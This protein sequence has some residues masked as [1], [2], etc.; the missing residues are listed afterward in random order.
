MA[1]EKLASG[2][3]HPV[4]ESPAPPP[5]PSTSVNKGRKNHLLLKPEYKT[6]VK[7]FIVSN[8]YAA[9]QRHTFSY[10]KAAHLLLFDMAR[11]S[12]HRRSCCDLYRC[13]N[14]YARHE[15]DIWYAPPSSYLRV[16]KQV[17]IPVT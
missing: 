11:Q 14:Y 12:L 10:S 3:E 2:G 16:Y 8:R 13:W 5:E 15:H 4:P 7:D 17:V 6:A 1:E 9:A